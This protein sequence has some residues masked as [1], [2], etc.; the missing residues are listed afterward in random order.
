MKTINSFKYNN[1]ELKLKPDTV[2][3]L[4]AKL[5]QLEVLRQLISEMIDETLKDIAEYE[6]YQAKQSDN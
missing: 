4:T 5:N 2:Q 6:A 1:E 3:D